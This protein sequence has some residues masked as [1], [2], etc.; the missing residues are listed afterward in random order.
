[1]PEAD[2]SSIVFHSRLLAFTI[3]SK[4]LSF[5]ASLWNR[6]ARLIRALCRRE[7]ISQ[8]MSCLFGTVAPVRRRLRVVCYPFLS[9]N[10]VELRRQD[11]AGRRRGRARGR[12]VHQKVRGAFQLR[13]LYF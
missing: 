13:A 5:R 6:S 11:G 10:S 3:T 8:F 7:I 9:I 1:M 12:S 4:Q 2:A